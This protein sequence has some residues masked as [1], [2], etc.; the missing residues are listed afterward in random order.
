M[1]LPQSTRTL[2][3]VSA[4]GATALHVVWDDGTAVTIDLAS[5]IARHQ[6]F[7]FLPG[8]SALFAT[9]SL[10]PKRRSVTGSCRAETPCSL[11]VDALW[12]LQHGLP[13]PIADMPASPRAFRLHL[14]AVA[15]LNRA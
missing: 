1:L 8:E 15:L 2:H 6:G 3:A 13:P 5:V 9:V 12:R 4:V 7:A 10:T 11:H 14:Q